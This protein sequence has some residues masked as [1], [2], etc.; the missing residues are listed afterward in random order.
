MT[1]KIINSIL[2]FFKK[3]EIKNQRKIITFFV[4]VCIAIVFWF[5]NALNKSYTVDIE[6]PVKYINLPANRVLSNSPVDKYT[7]TVSSYGFT[8]LRHKLSLAF[9]PL[10]F[11]VNEFTRGQLQETNRSR[12]VISTKQFINRFSSQISNELKINAIHPDT[13]VFSFEKMKKRMVKVIPKVYI[14][15]VAQH[16]LRRSIILTPDSVMVNGPESVMDTLSY[17]YTVSQKY[18]KVKEPIHRNIALKECK[19]LTYNTSRVMMIIPVEEFTEKNLMVPVYVNDLPEGVHVNLF[20]EKVR[21]CFQVSLSR[22]KE[23]KA[24]EFRV[25]VEYEDIQQQKET[26]SLKLEVQPKD[27]KTVSIYPSRIEYLIEK[28]ER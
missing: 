18:T 24:D 12:Y 5:L 20:P 13:V 8:I 16:D 23:I 19:P 2:Y 1:N 7:L 27:I 15:F 26:L 6:F 17:V 4:C 14:D 3:S 28:Q 25:C 11:D 9:S 21:V 22:F 10:V